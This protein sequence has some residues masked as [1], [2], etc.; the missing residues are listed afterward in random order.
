MESPAC[1]AAWPKFPREKRARERSRA[2]ASEES[3]FFHRVGWMQIA[4]MQHELAGKTPMVHP[5]KDHREKEKNH[6]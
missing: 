6:A 2:H 3:N 4:E 1:Q 5:S